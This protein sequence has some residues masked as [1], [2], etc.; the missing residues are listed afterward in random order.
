ME[1]NWLIYVGGYDGLSAED[2]GQPMLFS[3]VKID[4]IMG[5]EI[6]NI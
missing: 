1:A 6:Y 3:L 5:N 2:D 4:T